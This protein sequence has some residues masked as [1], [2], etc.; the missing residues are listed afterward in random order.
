MFKKWRNILQDYT[1]RFLKYVWPFFNIPHD[2]IFV[3][4]NLIVL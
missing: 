1:A 2:Y 4:V 3:S